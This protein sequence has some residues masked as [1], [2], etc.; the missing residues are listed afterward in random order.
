M[1]TYVNWAGYANG[2][3]FGL[4][5]HSATQHGINGIKVVPLI[6]EDLISIE[7]GCSI[8]VVDSAGYGI[9]INKISPSIFLYDVS[10]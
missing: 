5:F 7:D 2:G 10:L 4:I 1:Y 8:R 9:V 6:G 3:A